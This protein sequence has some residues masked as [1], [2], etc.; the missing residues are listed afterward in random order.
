MKTR[1][2]NFG[3][4]PRINDFG[5]SWCTECGKLFAFKLNHRELD[6]NFTLESSKMKYEQRIKKPDV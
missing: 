5:V 1:C 6:K 4:R 2:D 3:C